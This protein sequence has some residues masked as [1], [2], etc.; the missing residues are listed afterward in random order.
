MDQLIRQLEKLTNQKVQ[1]NE[2]EVDLQLKKRF[3]GVSADFEK[4]LTRLLHFYASNVKEHPE[5]KSLHRK[6]IKLQT[7]FKAL[8][9][10]TEKYIDLGKEALAFAEDATKKE[11]EIGDQAQVYEKGEKFIGPLVAYGRVHSKTAEEGGFTI[12]FE[13]QK[14]LYNSTEYDIVKID[15]EEATFEKVYGKKKL[16]EVDPIAE[17]EKGKEVKKEPAK[18]AQP[19]AEKPVQAK[20]EPIVPTQGSNPIIFSRVAQVTKDCV[21]IIQ[22]YVQPATSDVA[23]A[24]KR[25]YDEFL[26][27]L[28]RYEVELPLDMSQTSIETLQALNDELKT[29]IDVYEI[30]TS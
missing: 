14:G 21:E 30:P 22:K 4:D 12:S 19:K 28:K 27:I 18:P 24:R 25:I 8:F 9:D 3:Y 23:N 7:V 5:L 6:V 26:K 29:F 17:P 16:T 1:L 15:L 20:P 10:E 2:G 13:D 11:V